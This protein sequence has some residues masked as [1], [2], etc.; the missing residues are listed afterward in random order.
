MKINVYRLTSDH[1]YPD[2]SPS[3]TVKRGDAARANPNDPL[4]CTVANAARRD[5]GAIAVIVLRTKAMFVFREPNGHYYVEHFQLGPT[6]KAVMTATDWAKTG[7]G[8]GVTLDFRPMRPSYRPEAHRERNSNRPGGHAAHPGSRP[9]TGRRADPLT[10]LGI[11]KGTPSDWMFTVLEPEP[12]PERITH[13][14]P[15]QTGLIQA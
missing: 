14:Q 7:I 12:E 6:S 5:S 8:V 9:N 11:R 15:W 4:N 13:K 10:A 2:H 3:P 1:R